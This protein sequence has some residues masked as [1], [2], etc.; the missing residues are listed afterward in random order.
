MG[1]ILKNEPFE[2][3]DKSGCTK[4]GHVDGY[5]ARQHKPK[6][7]EYANSNSA[8]RAAYA[9]GEEHLKDIKRIKL[10]NEKQGWE[11]YKTSV[12]YYPEDVPEE[13]VGSSN[14][15]MA[16]HF[17]CIEREEENGSIAHAWVFRIPQ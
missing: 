1:K 2:N 16:Y 15:Q 7:E 17:V 11:L 13:L 14:F 4:V 10:M 8:I 6:L 9:Q 12:E 5:K 3:F